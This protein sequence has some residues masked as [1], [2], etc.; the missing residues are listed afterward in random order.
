MKHLKSFNSLNEGKGRV[1]IKDNH[2][3]AGETNLP[4]FYTTSKDY[5]NIDNNKDPQETGVNADQFILPVGN[6]FNYLTDIED[7]IDS[8]QV[9]KLIEPHIK[10]FNNFG[11][12]PSK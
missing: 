1:D 2:V 5:I 12:N 8:N 6:D 9:K 10:K 7:H 3:R 11:F 4:Q